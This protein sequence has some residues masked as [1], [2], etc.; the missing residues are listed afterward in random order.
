MSNQEL[1]V[2]LAVL[3]ALVVFTVVLAVVGVR[4]RRA[5]D[6]EVTAL[7]AAEVAALCQD[8]L[9]G[10]DFLWAVWNDTA[11]AG[12]MKQLVRNAQDQT[13]SNISKPA[14][15]L[16]GVLKRFDL[17]GKHYEIV[18]NHELLSGR[19]CLREIGQDTVLLSSDTS[20]T[21]TTFF[22]G[23]GEQEL[24]RVPQCM[25]STKGFRPVM[26]EGNAVGKLMVGLNNSL[27]RLLTLPK[28][29]YSELEQVFLLASE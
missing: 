3:G 26:V 8:Q 5:A 18:S 14:L 20:M 11:S 21:G 9:L 1:M 23:D 7:R 15:S 28:G 4:M 10:P 6:A 29:R 25:M 22:R 13:V 12:A 24:F 17:A 27:T 16:D 2:T 19:S